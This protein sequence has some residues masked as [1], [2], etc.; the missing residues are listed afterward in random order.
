[1]ATPS[2]P[3]GSGIAGLIASGF[4]ASF[5]LDEEFRSEFRTNWQ[6]MVAAVILMFFAFAAP[7]FATPF[8]IKA[9]IQEFGWTR[10]QAVL[11]VSLKYLT[12]AV[13]SVVVGYFIDRF[14]IRRM[15][16]A[17]STLGGAALLSFLF[18]RDLPTYYLG[19]VLLGLATPGTIVAVKV[20]VSRTFLT[21]QGTAMGIALLGVGLGGMVVSAVIPHLFDAFD[22]RVGMA[23]LSGGIWLVALPMLLFILPRD[24]FSR[25][26]HVSAMKHRKG[27]PPVAMG[28]PGTSMTTDRSQIGTLLR[29]KRFWLGGFVVATAGLVDQAFVQHLVTYFEIDLGMEPT[30]VGYVISAYFFIGLFCRP[31]IGNFF[32]AL[33][34]KGVA[35]LYLAL[36]AACLLALAVANP[37]ILILFILFRAIAHAAVLM[38]TVILAKHVFGTGNLGLLLGIY[39]AFVNAGFAIGPWLLARIY[40]VTGDY[41]IGFLLFAVLAA[42]ASAA[43]YFGLRPDY[44]LEVRRQKAEAQ[45]AGAAH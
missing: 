42:I 16:I 7:A 33:S 8:L 45:A 4:K 19:G 34:T 25:V 2:Q 35:V 21:C 22:W 18:T 15:L 10:E 32:D 14:G 3:T 26:E 11:V 31:A 5:K 38:D 27:G 13:F 20:F 17:L 37:V 23:I 28:P 39:T 12:G 29:D 36:C 40:D 41:R 9:V 6:V 24:L 44:W 1:M 30:T 43:L